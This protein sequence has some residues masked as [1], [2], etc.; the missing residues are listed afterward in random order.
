MLQAESSPFVI[1]ESHTSNYISEKDFFLIIQFVDDI[2]VSLIQALKTE[3]K[4]TSPQSLADFKE[5]IEKNLEDF[6]PEDYSIAALFQNE[7]IVYLYT[8]GKGVIYINRENILNKLTDHNN[9][10]SGFLKNGDLFILGLES[11]FEK[12]S[13]A[14][15]THV[16]NQESPLEI[17]NELTANMPSQ[18]DHTVLFIRFFEQTEDEEVST[19]QEDVIVP[20]KRT[21]ILER[22][23]H[24]FTRENVSANK[25][26][27][28]IVAIVLLALL[29]WSVGFGIQRR[30][31]SEIAKKIS[32]HTQI[33]NTKLSEAEDLATLSTERSKILIQEAKREVDL[34]KKDIGNNN[35]EDIIA[36]STMISKK[37]NQIFKHE[38]K[39]A[40][41]F[42]DLN[43]IADKSVGTQMY[44]DGDQLDIINNNTGDVYTISVSKKSKGTFNSSSVKDV[45]A[46]SG[47]E[48]DIYF[49]KTDGVY[50]NTNGKVDKVIKSDQWGDVKDFAIF[51]GNIYVLDAGK[52]DIYK[53]LV[54]EKGFSDK[55]SYIKSGQN[56]QLPGTQSL[57][58]DGS[59]YVAGGEIIDKLTS[60]VEETFN[61]ILPNS[62]T[63]SYTKVITTKDLNKVYLFDKSTGSVYVVSKDGQY[64]RQIVSS[65]LKQADD[66]TVSEAEKMVLV[67]VKNKIYKLGLD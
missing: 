59:L 32:Y 13:S 39:Q 16:F 46:V 35:A 24:R 40:E 43:L 65:I 28:V 38:N 63:P 27:T 54:A 56:I 58:I 6:N 48:G 4:K 52:Q 11:F 60:G 34:L 23:R 25:K 49:L 5:A 57:A 61:V 2:P 20:T 29:I 50:K 41:E 51:N 64:E 45:K 17:T 7:H 47:S 36:L 42:Y 37:E 67:L 18:I 14:G 33:I 62:S 31:K 3:I 9:T 55:T 26:L 8:H 10:A 22:F 12:T 21:P 44:L 19:S 15:L 66:V 30:A 1:Q 53:Y